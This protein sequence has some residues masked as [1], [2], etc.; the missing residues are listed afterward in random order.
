MAN[1]DA[2]PGGERNEAEG[3]SSGSKR[4]LD[5]DDVLAASARFAGHGLTFALATLVFLL[6][7]SWADGRLG[8]EPLLT[9]VGGLV[10]ASA[11]FWHLYVNIA[12]SSDR[13][14]EDDQG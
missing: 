13:T 9:I 11:G 12:V 4:T 8:T 10:G 2:G 5:T 14:N 3:S 1:T 7:G 6:V